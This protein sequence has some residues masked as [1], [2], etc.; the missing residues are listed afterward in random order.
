MTAAFDEIKTQP[1][2]FL[3]AWTLQGLWVLLTAAAAL[4]VIT[5]GARE[6]LGHRGHHGHRG[7]ADRYTA[8][9]SSPTRQ[10]SKFKEPIDSN[11]GKFINTGP[12][13][14][15][16]APELLRRDPAV[17]RHGHRGR[18][19]A[20]GLAV[21]NPDLA[22]VCGVLVDQGQRYPAT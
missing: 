20:A 12:L 19:G 9:K 15:V 17:D 7:M 13:G 8:S 6:P 11:K 16:A 1:L 22:S 21:G 4:A 5:G 10:K 18:S 14:L 3:M 2:R